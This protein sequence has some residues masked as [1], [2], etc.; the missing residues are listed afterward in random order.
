M[1]EDGLDRWAF[2][3]VKRVEGSMDMMAW[4]KV[5]NDDVDIVRLRDMTS[6]NASGTNLLGIHI[7]ESS[8]FERE[9]DSSLSLSLRPAVLLCPFRLMNISSIV[10]PLY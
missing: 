10:C 8:I 5:Q 7:P 9:A 2:P 1:L 4:V 6:P 3:S